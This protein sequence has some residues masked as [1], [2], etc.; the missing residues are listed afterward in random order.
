MTIEKEVQNMLRLGLIEPSKSPWRSHLVLVPQP[1][2]LVWFCINFWH[3]NAVS[4][5]NA[6]PMPHVDTFIHRVGAAKYLSTLDLTKGYWQIPLDNDSI[7][8]T[9]FAT[10]SGLYHFMKMSFVL[11]GVTASFQRLMALKGPSTLLHGLH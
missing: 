2:G 10:P 7:E 1:D 9:A 6:Y 3:L 5:F 4:T 8:K 11:H